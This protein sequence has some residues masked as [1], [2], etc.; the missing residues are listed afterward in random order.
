MNIS[1]KS[2]IYSKRIKMDA[3]EIISL[4]LKGYKERNRNMPS[5]VG[6]DSNTS[7]YI[8]MKR[9]K[10]KCPVQIRLSNH[11]TYLRT[12]VDRTNLENSNERLQD[13][14]HCIN[15]SIVFIDD[16]KDLTNDCEGQT[17]CDNCQITPCIP[18][19]FD[20]QNDLGHPFQ[21]QQ[22]TYCSRT[23][24]KR[25]LKGIVGAIIRALRTGKYTDPLSKVTKRKAANKTLDSSYPI[26]PQNN[27][28]DKNES[29]NMKGKNTIRLTESELK[30]VI[31]ESVKKV[32]NEAPAHDWD[33]FAKPIKDNVKQAALSAIDKTFNE[34]WN[35]YTNGRFDTDFDG[36][37]D[38]AQSLWAY[39][40]VGLMSNIQKSVQEAF[41][42]MPEGLPNWRDRYDRM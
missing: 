41:G 21:V 9:G 39:M 19:T 12:W 42:I 34:M 17:N 29:K 8:S 7:F 13:P 35:Y 30:K 18:Q 2:D 28:T 32:L 11:G 36:S 38:K 37:M 22:Y 1:F 23:I 14:S 16:G 40:R 31:T 26:T 20:G 4:I 5:F 6:N 25:Y 10:D 24:R 3:G 15:I 27:K 33:N